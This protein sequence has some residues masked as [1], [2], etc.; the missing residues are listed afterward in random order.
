MIDRAFNKLYLGTHVP[1]RKSLQ[2]GVY[3][4]P[5]S[6]V[7]GE[8][9]P[10]QKAKAEAN[11]KATSAALAEGKPRVPVTPEQADLIQSKAQ[12]VLDRGTRVLNKLNALENE[13]HAALM[14]AGET[15]D[16]SF[17]I[18][19]SR[20]PRLRQAIL[21]IFGEKRPTITYEMYREALK[22]KKKMEA[23]ESKDVFK[24][25]TEDG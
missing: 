20:K 18:D 16:L 13:I 5:E 3:E 17:N 4:T 14:D 19:V 8:L 2:H 25:G 1:E 7:S 24:I 15:R 23:E 21:V 22:L 10:E 11:I 6:R 12:S 9:T